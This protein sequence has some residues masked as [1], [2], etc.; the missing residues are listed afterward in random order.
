MAV[1]TFTNGTTQLIYNELMKP[2]YIPLIRKKY[3]KGNLLR[4][5]AFDEWSIGTMFTIINKIF[6]NE[7]YIAPDISN[8]FGV[9]V[10]TTSTPGKTFGG[11]YD[12]MTNPA[13][14]GDFLPSSSFGRDFLKFRNQYECPSCNNRNYMIH[15]YTDDNIEYYLCKLCLKQSKRRKI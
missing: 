6:K 3:L 14:R 1:M 5:R 4:L 15:L 8:I 10:I 7:T 11:F 13:R 2:K 12:F 9:P